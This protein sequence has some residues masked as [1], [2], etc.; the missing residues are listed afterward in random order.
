M[1]TMDIKNEAVEY[2]GDFNIDEIE[3]MDFENIFNAF[4]GKGVDSLDE[5]D[6]NG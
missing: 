6:Y 3:Q 5:D 1:T 2:D 4:W